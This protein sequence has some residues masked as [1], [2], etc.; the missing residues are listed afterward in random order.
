MANAYISN[1]YAEKL[2]DFSL[3]VD[4]LKSRL[5]GQGYTLTGNEP[6]KLTVMPKSRGYTGY[7]LAEKSFLIGAALKQSGYELEEKPILGHA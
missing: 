7:E 5:I 6:L 3:R 1:G 4:A 2:A